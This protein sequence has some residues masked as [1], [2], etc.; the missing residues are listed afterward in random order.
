MWVRGL[1]IWLTSI[2]SVSRTVLLWFGLQDTMQTI[3]LPCKAW[4]GGGAGP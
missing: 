4:V 3:P 2:L 1:A